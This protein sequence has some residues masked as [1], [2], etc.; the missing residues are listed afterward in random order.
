MR[1]RQARPRLLQAMIDAFRLPD[2]R[3]RILITIGIVVI[4]RFIAH[5]PLP[6]VD[7]G[8]LRDFFEQSALMGMLDMFS[9]GA[10]KNFSIAAMGVYP[11]ITASIV[12]TLMTPVIPRLH[13]GDGR[14]ALL[15]RAESLVVEK[16]PDFCWAV[17]NIEQPPDL[18]VDD[19]LPRRDGPGR[20]RRREVHRA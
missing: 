9:G 16:D 20:T 1:P 5:I 7:P 19:V 14:P 13:P 4:F 12:M 18:R 11:Y 2:L 10:M 17:C 6:G 8:G 3:R 15:I